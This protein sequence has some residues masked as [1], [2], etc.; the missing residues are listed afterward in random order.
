MR[1]LYPGRI[2]I[3]FCGGRENRESREKPSE[4]GENNNK[5]NPRMAPGWYRTWATLVGRRR[6]HHCAVPAPVLLINNTPSYH[7]E[8]FQV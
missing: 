2:G 5:L 6:S 4:Q 7:V 8:M 1:V 3:G